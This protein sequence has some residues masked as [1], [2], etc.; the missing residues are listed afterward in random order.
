MP[1][2]VSQNEKRVSGLWMLLGKFKLVVPQRGL[3]LTFAK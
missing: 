2:S 1:A 3:G